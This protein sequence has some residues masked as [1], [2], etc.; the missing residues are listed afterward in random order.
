MTG[1]SLGTMSYFSQVF[2][3][4]TEPDHKAGTEIILQAYQNLASWRIKSVPAFRNV[5]L[6]E[7]G[8]I[9]SPVI[10]FGDNETITG[11]I[12]AI[13]RTVRE[14]RLIDF[15]HIG[16]DVI[17]TESLRSREAFEAHELIMPF[18]DWV[19]LS[20]WEGGH[21]AYFYYRFPGS[22]MIVATEIYGLS[23]P[24]LGTLCRAHDTFLLYDQIVVTVEGPGKTV[25]R[26]MPLADERL[27]PGVTDFALRGSN[28]LDPLVTFLRFLNDASCPVT[29]VPAP[30]KLNKQRAARGKQPIPAHYDVNVAAYI[31]HLRAQETAAR[32]LQTGRQG[33]THASPVP[34][35]R[36][37][38]KRHLRS[39]EIVDVRSSKINFRTEEEIKRL[40]YKF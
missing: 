9:A 12:H 11:L 20:S 3:G 8:M 37:A 14:G 22:N 15:G 5:L 40:F 7:G 13:R 29:K 21:V 32:T 17:K 30:D 27:E 10:D 24:D 16:N 6:G 1:N 39:G 34:H 23:I 31:T 36:R 35:Y 19:A 25:V 4:K 18:D 38:H 33:G 2:P 26:P 28:V